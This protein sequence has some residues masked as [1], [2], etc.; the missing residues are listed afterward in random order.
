MRIFLV[1][2]LLTLGTAGTAAAETARDLFTLPQKNILL[3]DP[4]DVMDS[5]Q[6][7][8]NIY[9]TNC[10]KAEADS[11]L[12]EYA[13][14]Q[15]AC[16]ASAMPEIMTM[17]DTQKLFDPKNKDDAPFT[18]FM[19]LGY[20]PCLE[21]TIPKYTYDACFTSPGMK[22]LV[23]RHKICQCM[24]KGMGEVMVKYANSLLPGA[25]VY[26]YDIDR[27]TDDMLSYA[28][29]Q[30]T[31]ET[32]ADYYNTTCMQGYFFSKSHRK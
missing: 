14:M 3:A 19:T 15:C 6:D 27:A 21:Q 1:V 25:K 17:A 24:S 32:Q 11:T 28:I 16:A 20:G 26:G 2:L 7:Y 12:K 29:T 18:R 30:R 8:A 22:K 10:I 9:Y 4:K 5:V 13:A 23:H 31:F